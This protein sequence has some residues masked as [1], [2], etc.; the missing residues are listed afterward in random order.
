MMVRTQ[1]SLH[2][3]RHAKARARAASHGISLA[4]YVRRLVDRDLAE[5]PRGADRSVIFDL[6]ASGG[7]DIAL[8]KARMIGEA[9][10]AGKR[11]ANAP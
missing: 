8:G 9:T 6:G 4:E 7:A 1:I 2:S 10:G 11:R 3:E 5:R